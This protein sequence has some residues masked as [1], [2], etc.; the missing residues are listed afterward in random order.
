MH[1]G[2]AIFFLPHNE[3]ILKR[4]QG[5]EG[6]EPGEIQY[7]AILKHPRA[8]IYVNTKATHILYI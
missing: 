2:V 5:R 6:A 8:Q 1:A 7:P 3:I 4:A